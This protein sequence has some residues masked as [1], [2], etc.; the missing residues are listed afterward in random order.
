MASEEIPKEDL[1]NQTEAPTP[2]DT[3]SGTTTEQSPKMSA[4]IVGYTGEVGKELVRQLAKTNT[5]VKVLLIGRRKV[6]YK[7]ED[8]ANNPAIVSPS[9]VETLVHTHT[10]QKDFR[11]HLLGLILC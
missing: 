6:E 10:R 3:S 4:F 8:I 11:S 7:D 1:A 9:L 2:P 5:F